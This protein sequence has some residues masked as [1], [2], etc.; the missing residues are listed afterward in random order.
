MTIGNKVDQRIVLMVKEDFLA[1]LFLI[2]HL[3]GKNAEDGDEF[4]AD[5][6]CRNT[7][8]SLFSFPFTDDQH[9]VELCVCLKDM[10]RGIHS[11]LRDDAVLRK[12]VIAGRPE[13][14]VKSLEITALVPALCLDD[15]VDLQC[16]PESF[17]ISRRVIIGRKRIDGK[18]LIICMFRRILRLS[19]ICHGP[20]HAAEF[21]VTACG[22]HEFVS[23][24]RIRKK[25]R[26]LFRIPLLIIFCRGREEP[27]DAAV[28]DTALH[29]LPVYDEV[30]A[31][32][33]VETAVFL[34]FQFL[35]E[36]N[37][38]L[39]QMFLDFCS[40]FH[41]QCLSSFSCARIR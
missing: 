4:L 26:S 32:I 38:P 11:A 23:V 16:K 41:K 1:V 15:A 17:H 19:V 34:I 21:R 31:H 8:S 39:V 6:S 36:R 20:E 14:S 10:Q 9:P 3:I 37:D 2:I 24:A 12:F 7:S 25:F 40:H 35:P 27:C 33:S 13:R 5:F 30:I 22:S 28:K 29:R 18:C